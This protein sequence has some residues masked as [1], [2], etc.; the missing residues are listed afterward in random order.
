MTPAQLA[1]AL[2]DAYRA[3][4]KAITVTYRGAGWF[5]TRPTAASVGFSIRTPEVLT[6]IAQL[7]AR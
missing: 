7:G 2:Q 3:Q 1:T 5:Y 4:G 6:T